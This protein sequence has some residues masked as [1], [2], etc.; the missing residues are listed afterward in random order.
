M[1]K[2]WSTNPA[3]VYERERRRRKMAE[4]AKVCRYCGETKVRAEFVTYADECLA[5][6]AVAKTCT[7]CDVR[8]PLEEFYVNGRGVDGRSHNCKACVLASP[9]H[10]PSDRTR[11]RDAARKEQRNARLR[12]RRLADPEWAQAQ[13]DR[14][15][16][17]HSRIV[18]EGANVWT[19][20]SDAGWVCYLCGEAMGH[21]EPLEVDH[22][23]P[24]ALG[25][26]D[27][28]WNVA[29]THRACN[30][31]KSDVHPH[32]LTWAAPTSRPVVDAALAAMREHG[33]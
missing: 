20:A 19:L 9:S 16:S 24:V 33:H 30:R 10:R 1:P 31:R 28:R 7:G 27:R 2:A 29:A 8:K 6:R 25:G 15:R 32:L 17:R 22:V 14:S 26:L 11:A 12:A 3:S 23:L 21:D 5:C 18:T 13:R 4:V